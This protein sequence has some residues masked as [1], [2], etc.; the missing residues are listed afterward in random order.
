MKTS[1]LP[2]FSLLCCML[3]HTQLKASPFSK[4]PPKPLTIA[5]HYSLSKPKKRVRIPKPGKGAI[6]TTQSTRLSRPF[7]LYVEFLGPTATSSL[8]AQFFLGRYFS[9]SS[10]LG[11]YH[12]Y[13]GSA[14]HI[15]VAS[16]GVK[17]HPYLGFRYSKRKVVGEEDDIGDI[18]YVPVG[19]Q[20]VGF[21]GFGFAAEI[22][23]SNIQYERKPDL[24]TIFIGLKVGFHLR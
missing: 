18:I 23:A 10:G 19:M 1:L 12:F 8:S 11:P 2:F 9:M 6:N 14:V 21:R 24:L 22:A 17:W 5:Q 15:P 16:L 7:G 20:Y 13:V 3:I 4:I